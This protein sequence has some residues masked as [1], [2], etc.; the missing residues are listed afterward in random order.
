MYEPDLI[1]DVGLN[2]GGDTAYYLHR[3]FRVVAIEAHPD[4]AER[5]RQ[6]FADAIR[7]GRLTLLNVAIAPE[8]GVA[9]LIVNERDWGRNTLN[10]LL[11]HSTAW[12]GVP[13]HTL[14][15]RAVR[16]KDVLAEYG[17]PYYLKVDI[18]TFDHYCLEDLDPSDL[19]PCTS[20]F[21]AQ[22]IRDLVTAR[23]KNYTNFKVIRQQ[24]HC[25]AFYDPHIHQAAAESK[26]SAWP[27]LVPALGL[28]K[29]LRR[30]G[31]S[32][33]V[34]KRAGYQPRSDWYF[35]EGQSGPFGEE[36][37]GPWRSFAQTAMTWMA[38]DLG[39]IGP[40]FQEGKWQDIHCRAENYVPAP[41][42][43]SP[44]ARDLVRA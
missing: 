7:E 4:Q 35:A 36:T 31:A 6:R 3:G 22:S 33:P 5:A 39:L 17:V 18:E 20:P 10:A 32:T 15:V 13:M 11:P 23:E 42:E 28:S 25:Q 40:D 29:R 2:D 37:D 12:A 38:Y 26:P 43:T 41:N 14:E 34:M 30:D 16:F 9:Q 8:A 44:V 19:P 21:E 24:D 1:Y 27:A